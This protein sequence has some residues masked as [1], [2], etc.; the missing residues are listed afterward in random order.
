M[1][2]VAL[3]RTALRDAGI[4]VLVD[5]SGAGTR[6]TALAAAHGIANHEVVTSNGSWLH[7]GY[8][9]GFE[10]LCLDLIKQCEAATPR[11]L[12]KYEQTL[13]RLWPFRSSAAFLVPRDL[14]NTAN[15]EERT[16]FYHHEYQNKLLVGLGEFILQALKTSNREVVLIIDNCQAL[17]ATSRSLLEILVRLQ[18]KCKR[19]RFVILD[20]EGALLIANAPRFVLPPLTQ[21]DFESQLDV[22]SLA[23]AQKDLLFTR[24]NGNLDV[25]A[26]LLKCM[27]RG[28]DATNR[29]SA[30]AIVDLFLASIPQE[31]RVEMA[32][33]F[34][35][36]GLVGDLINRRNAETLPCGVLDRLNSEAHIRRLTQY[37]SGSAPL[38]LAHA[39]ALSNKFERV[40]ALVQPCEI[41]MGIGLYDTWFEF[42]AANYSDPELQ[43]HGSGDDPINGLFINAAFVLYAMGYSSSSLPFLEAFLRQFPLSRFVP[44]ALYAQSMTY[45]RYQ[46][47]VDI[48]RAEAC[49]VANLRLIEEKFANH[50]RYQYIKVFAENAYAY[51]K[52]RQGDLN[53]ALALCEHGLSEI[54]EA[55]G[56]G[57]FLLHRSI[58]VY[59][60][61]QV[62][63]L[64]GD[65]VRA[66]ARLRDAI[67]LDPYYA[68]Y[69]NDLGNLLARIAGR[70]REALDAYARAI[71][72]SPP[73]YEAYLN[74]GILRAQGVD[75]TGAEADFQ[76]ALEIK[77]S[78][79]RA[80]RELGNL[81]LGRGDAALALAAYDRA[82]RHEAHDPDLNANAGVAASE[83]GFTER[84]I[85]L[86]QVAI[87]SNPHHAAAHNN[88]AAE[89]LKLGRFEQALE[90]AHLAVEHGNDPDFEANL[91]VVERLGSNAKLS[92]L[93]AET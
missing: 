26:A 88:L 14:T 43:K 40:E 81:N 45:G 13:K 12:A 32:T 64:A 16:R 90:H 86:A 7:G 51:I 60:T 49:A 29:L 24:S 41:L 1:P 54:V 46:V 65:V 59:N 73:Y 27:G 58:L 56:E 42:F 72:L 68:E 2:F 3:I 5:T 34:V 23:S 76:R 53:S 74:R 6:S 92:A 75:V 52:A 61:S 91:G 28:L 57:A 4:V 47:P 8:L 10:E 9:A 82:L 69:Y 21:L 63:E 62:Y 36:D 48:P 31:R 35:E 19:I 67:E 87:S 79:W 44:T 15:R 80:M 70:E 55:Y 89:F 78:E 85:A 33:A 50:P 22:E 17:C 20:R 39:V 37:R 30:L 38:I 84:A 77:P 11:L 66:E 93:S 25:G 71:E 18:E 83:L